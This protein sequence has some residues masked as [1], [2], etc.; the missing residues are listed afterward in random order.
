QLVRAA[1]RERFLRALGVARG[2]PSCFSLRSGVRV[3]GVFGAA[4]VEFQTFQVDSLRTPLGVEAAALL[5]GSDVL[6]FSFLLQ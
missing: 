5:R 1:L 4:D 2:R 6:A 3:D